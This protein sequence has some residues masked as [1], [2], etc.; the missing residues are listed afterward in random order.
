MRDQGGTLRAGAQ[1]DGLTVLRR[2]PWQYSAMVSS[3][4]DVQEW[5]AHILIFH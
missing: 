3:R 4:R 2:A 5:T 1:E